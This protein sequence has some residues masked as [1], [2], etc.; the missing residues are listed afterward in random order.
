MDQK[1]NFYT[2][3]ENAKVEIRKRWQDDMLKERVREYLGGEIPEPLHTEPRAVLSR[4][5][6]SPDHELLHFLDMSHELNIKPLG[7]EGVDDKFVTNNEDKMVLVKL[8]FFEGFDKNGNAISRSK[9]IVNLDDAKGKKISEIKT[10]WGENLVDFHHGLL[11]KYVS[12]PVDI[13]DDFRWF[14]EKQMKTSIGEYYK[15]FLAIF[16][17]Y[18]VLFENFT[19]VGDEARFTQEIFFPAFNDVTEIFGL[20]PLIIPAQ[21]VDEVMDVYWWCYPKAVMKEIKSRI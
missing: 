7:L 18:G 5:I 2:T 20:S 14:T 19:D 12:E 15:K 16:V 17:C 1:K 11:K 6:I 3:I 8:R 4:N 13:Y 10:L 21:P 9:L